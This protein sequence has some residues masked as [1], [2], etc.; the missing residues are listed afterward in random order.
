M[1]QGGASICGG[2]IIHSNWVLTAAHCC[3][4]KARVFGRFGQ[5]NMNGH[6]SGEFTLSSEDFIVHPGRTEFK[7][8]NDFC[9][10]K[11]TNSIMQSGEE[12]C[13]GNCVAIACLPSSPV[14]SGQATEYIFE[15]DNDFLGSNEGFLG[16]GPNIWDFADV[17]I[18]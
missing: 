2:T 4:D 16:P 18:R 9:L 10:V 7:R 13:S 11:F 3:E 12:N 5:H 15:N 14:P 6:D 17:G 8:N 1:T